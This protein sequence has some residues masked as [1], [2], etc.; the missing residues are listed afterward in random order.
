MVTTDM[1]KATSS[2]FF[3]P[4]PLGLEVAIFEKKK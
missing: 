1:H 2:A 4:T 3:Q